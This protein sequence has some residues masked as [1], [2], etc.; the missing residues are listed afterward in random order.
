[1]INKSKNIHWFPGHMKKAII[2]ISDSLKLVDFVVEMLDSRIPY[3]SQN[4]YIEHV[5][6]TKPRLYILTKA[7]LADPIIT[8]QW[9]IFF[10]STAIALFA[11]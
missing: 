8:K 6:E 4:E 5:I 7:D 3:S 1:M 11:F 10:K 9:V 2:K